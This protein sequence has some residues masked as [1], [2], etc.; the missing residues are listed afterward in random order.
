MRDLESS[1]RKE[2]E[3]AIIENVCGRERKKEEL[4]SSSGHPMEPMS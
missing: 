3:K 1:R 2:I 4:D